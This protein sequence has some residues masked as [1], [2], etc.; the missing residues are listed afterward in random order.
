MKN[1]TLKDQRRDFTINIFRA[2][3]EDGKDSSRQLPQRKLDWIQGG[4]RGYL[5]TEALIQNL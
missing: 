5:S 3:T 2:A 4:M 1:D